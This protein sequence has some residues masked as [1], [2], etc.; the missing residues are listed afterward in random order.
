MIIKFDQLKNQALESEKQLEHAIFS[1]STCDTSE[2]E[3]TKSEELEAA[4]EEYDNQNTFSDS[5]SYD[6]EILSSMP[7][8][9]GKMANSWFSKDATFFHLDTEKSD[10]CTEEDI[11]ENT[12]EE[13]FDEDQEQLEESDNDEGN[14]E[15]VE[16]S[17]ENKLKR[18]R[19]TGN[20]GV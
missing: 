10:E 3:T 15:T 1:A 14:A 2:D 6:V 5:N 18:Q 19:K 9:L 8:K 4:C 16:D 17:L 11:D 7:I 13:K 20:F 12:Q